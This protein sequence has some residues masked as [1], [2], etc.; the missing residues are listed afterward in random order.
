VLAH[1]PWSEL[2]C[3]DR[4]KNE[5]KKSVIITDLRH[6]IKA[7]EHQQNNNGQNEQNHVEP[8]NVED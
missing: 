4:Q 2:R 1:E 8:K 3:Q 6:E 7:V 5:E